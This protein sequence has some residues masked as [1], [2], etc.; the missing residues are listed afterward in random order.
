M[1]RRTFLGAL[2][3][4]LLAAPLTAEAQQGGDQARGE[5]SLRQ[6]CPPLHDMRRPMILA[7]RLKRW[8]AAFLIVVGLMGCDFLIRWGEDLKVTAPRTSLGIGESVRITVKK[9]VSWFRTA[10]LTDPSKTIY[11]TTSESA[12]VVE[13]D[14]WV[15]CVGTNGR[16]RETAWISATNGKSHGHLSFD[17]RLEGPGPTLDFITAPTELPRLPDNA[18][19]PFVPCCATPVALKEGQQMRFKVQVRASGRD[20]TSSATGTRYTLFFGSGEPNDRRPS[21]I[22]GGSDAV[23]GRSFLLDEKQGAI[24]APDSIARLNHARV[25]VF[26][27]NGDLVGWREIVVIHK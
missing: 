22:T 2:A 17:L 6:R 13:P 1:D 3:S 27:R 11:T 21:I 25:I 19:S 10:E 23:S 12:L 18:Q 26:V 14:G 9:K 20:L 8:P 15:T 24:T 5:Q 4:G 7:A 16:P